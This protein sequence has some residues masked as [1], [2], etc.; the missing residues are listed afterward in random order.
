LHGFDG[1]LRLHGITLFDTAPLYGNGANE[2][3]LGD[4]LGGL[5]S[6]TIVTKFGLYADAGGRLYRDSRPETIRQSV[7]ASLRRL[8]RDRIDLLLQ[9]RVDPDTSDDDVQACIEDLIAAGKVGDFGLSG[10]SADEIERRSMAP[11]HERGAERAF[12]GDRPKG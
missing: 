9:H 12:S 7:E 2:Q 11:H 4:I 10:V 6:T 3:L 1:H 8:K 5:P